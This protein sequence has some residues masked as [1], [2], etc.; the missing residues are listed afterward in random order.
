[1]AGA[2]QV[3]HFAGQIGAITVFVNHVFYK[4]VRYAQG[5][6]SMGACLVTKR[7]AFGSAITV[8]GR[9]NQLWALDTYLTF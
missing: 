7:L 9:A 1:M 5:G 4:R 3:A 6:T 2:L 8:R